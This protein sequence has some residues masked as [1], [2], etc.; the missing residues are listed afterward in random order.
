VITRAQKTA[1]EWTQ[2]VYAP[3]ACGV[4]LF[5]ATWEKPINN[6]DFIESTQSFRDEG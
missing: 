2:I 5:T 4:F 1:R 6:R 3:N